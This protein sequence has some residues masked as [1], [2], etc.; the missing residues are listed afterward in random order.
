MNNDTEKMATSL[1]GDIVEKECNAQTVNMSLK[2]V[3]LPAKS[4][5]TPSNKDQM[6]KSM[7][8][9]MHTVG[10]SFKLELDT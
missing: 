3:G 2:E 1:H 5:E 4:C 7:D 9:E 8:Q 6:N 10:V